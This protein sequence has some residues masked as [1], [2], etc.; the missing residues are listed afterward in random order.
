MDRGQ[1]VKLLAEL[2]RSKS[3]KALNS[4]LKSAVVNAN[5]QAGAPGR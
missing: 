2:D 5:V 4:V 1:L 3:V